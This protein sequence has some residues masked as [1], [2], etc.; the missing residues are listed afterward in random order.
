MNDRAIP[1]SLLVAATFLTV[2][3]WLLSLLPALVP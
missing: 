1:M 2:L 3:V